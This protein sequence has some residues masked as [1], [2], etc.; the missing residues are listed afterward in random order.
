MAREALPGGRGA[1]PSPRAGEP[2]SVSQ[3]PSGPRALL[4]VVAAFHFLAS[5]CSEMK[6]SPSYAAPLS[7]LSRGRVED[8][9]FW[10]LGLRIKRRHIQS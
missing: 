9:C 3:F 6:V 7:P 1:C 10:L 4:Q 8:L 2:G 5:H